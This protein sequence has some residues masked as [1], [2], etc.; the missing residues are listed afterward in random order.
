MP[1][2]GEDETQELEDGVNETEGD[3]GPEDLEVDGEDEGTPDQPVEGEDDGSPEDEEIDAAA[4]GDK[5]PGRA[6]SRIQRL[7]QE[8]QDARREAAENK[9]L[10]EQA[11]S[12]SRQPAQPQE[13][14]E[15]EQARLALMTPEERVDYKLAKA[16][17]RNLQNTQNMQFQMQ[18]TADVAYFRG[19]VASDPVAAKY[20]DKVEAKLA[21]IRSK[22][23]NVN[24]E[25]LLDLLVGQD[26]R[27]KRAAAAPKQKAEADRRIARQKVPAGNSK[28]DTSAPKRGD[29][30]LEQRLENVT[31]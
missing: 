17:Q 26:M 25:A 30:S 19:L 20:K 10:L 21:E 5:K 4:A 2:P 23:Q 12:N 9:R 7:R 11:L 24:R 8:A 6:E 22:G 16:E 3:A 29:K 28:G 15:M 14:V 27:A 13:T 31:F 1:K 18:E